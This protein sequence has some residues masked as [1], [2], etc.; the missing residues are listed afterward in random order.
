L[1]VILLILI[2]GKDLKIEISSIRW[3]V[4]PSES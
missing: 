1:S 4:G 2:L 3:C